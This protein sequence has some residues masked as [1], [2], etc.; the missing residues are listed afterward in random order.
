M[1]LPLGT[2]ENGRCKWLYKRSSRRTVNVIRRAKKTVSA[3]LFF[4]P[5]LVTLI[6]ANVP[7]VTGDAGRL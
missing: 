6:T 1:T 5:L 7:S 4:T 3:Y 2:G